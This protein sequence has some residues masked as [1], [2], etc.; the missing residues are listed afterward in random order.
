MHFNYS[1]VVLQ[2]MRT[3]DPVAQATHALGWLALKSMWN[4]GPEQFDADFTTFLATQQDARVQEQILL[5]LSAA[6][7]SNVHKLSAFATSLIK[8]F[9][10]TPWQLCLRFAAGICT[11]QYCL[12]NA[13]MGA[14]WPLHG[15]E[16]VGAMGP[17]PFVHPEHTQ[18][19]DLLR[20]RW[21]LTHHSVDFR[22]LSF[23][24]KHPPEHRELI[25]LELCDANLRQL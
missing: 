5:T 6:D 16:L 11:S 4:I 17:C 24:C 8:E 10:G 22:A 21:G 13:T 12:S 25:L 18:G 14:A 2:V 19:W 3:A 7:L 23:L 1:E 15:D 20:E 9:K